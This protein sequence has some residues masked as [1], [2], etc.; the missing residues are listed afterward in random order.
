FPTGSWTG[1]NGE[2][3][4]V[5]YNSNSF[6]GDLS[7]GGFVPSSIINQFTINTGVAPVTV[8]AGGNYS[9]APL[10]TIAAA[11]GDAWNPG[12]NNAS[13]P[14]ATAVM[15]GTAVTGV[16]ITQSAS[17]GYY[18]QRPTLTFA[19][20]H[21]TGATA[22]VHSDNLFAENQNHQACAVTYNQV[23]SSTLS[24]SV[25]SLNATALSI[26]SLLP[27]LELAVTAANSA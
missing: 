16:T 25:D 20:T 10:V 24:A 21:G 9:Q 11:S 27:F 22:V 4:T 18:M 23:L 13:A 26:S 15:T 1:P 17:G 6:R 7:T 12:P 5:S 2:A 8:S 14:T 19:T 3:A